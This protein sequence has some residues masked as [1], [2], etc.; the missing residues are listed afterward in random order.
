MKYRH[1]F[2]DLD[3]TLW[4]FDANAAECL[5][6][7][8]RHYQLEKLGIFSETDF[9]ECFLAINH[10]LWEV[11]NVGDM[12]QQTLRTTR[13]PLVFQALGVPHYADHPALAEDYLRLSPQKSHLMPFARQVLEYLSRKYHLHLIT[14]GFSDTQ[15]V[16]TQSAG[17]NH[18]FTQVITSERAGCRKPQS[19]IFY[20]ARQ[21]ARAE[22]AESV[23]V[24]DNWICDVMGARN[25]GMDNIYYNPSGRMH[26]AEPTHDIRCLSELMTLL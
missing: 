16:K 9:T 7:L 17:I 1:V 2:F 4:N 12:S 8:Y 5:G 13:F 18:Y 19:G 20:F 24:G 11:Y 6:E 3:H 25:A 10:Q 23:M 22:T 14:N 21:V 26:D 15:A